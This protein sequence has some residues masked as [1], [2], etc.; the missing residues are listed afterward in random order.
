MSVSGCFWGV[1]SDIRSELK[2]VETRFVCISR[3]CERV[4]VGVNS[5]FWVKIGVRSGS[6]LK[7]STCKVLGRLGIINSPCETAFLMKLEVRYVE[8]KNGLR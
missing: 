2:V 3:R 4:N 6:V 5:A 8:N 1:E 7:N